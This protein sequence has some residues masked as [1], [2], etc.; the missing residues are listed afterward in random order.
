MATLRRSVAVARRLFPKDGGEEFLPRCTGIPL[1][2]AMRL[3]KIFLA[4][5]GGGVKLPYMRVRDVP[6][7]GVSF[8]E[9]EINFGVSFLVKSQVVMNFGMSF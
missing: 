5:P 3:D 7:F 6:F 1:K 4:A 8:F 2:S 9:Q